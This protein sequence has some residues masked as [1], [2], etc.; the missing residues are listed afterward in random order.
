M[1]VKILRLSKAA[2]EFNVGISTIVE[3]LH[4]KG[5]DIESNPNTKIETDAYDLLLKEFQSEKTVK[6]ESQKI[7]LSYTQHE[8]ISIENKVRPAKDKEDEEQDELFIKGT[9]VPSEH[10]IPSISTEK[11]ETKTKDTPEPEEPKEPEVDEVKTKKTKKEPAKEEEVKAVE[12]PEAET[13]EETGLKVLGKIDVDSFQKKKTTKKATPAKKARAKKTEK[14][15]SEKEEPPVKP[16]E[17]QKAATKKAS[18]KKKETPAAKKEEKAKEKLPAKVEVVEKV[19]ETEAIPEAKETKPKQQEN[20]IP[21]RVEK[22]DGPKIMGK[23][24]LPAEPKK[25]EKKPV[26]SSKDD[27]IDVRKKKRRRIKKDESEKSAADKG[28]PRERQRGKSRRKDKTKPEVSEEEIQKQIKE[29]L[30]R[31]AP[32]GKSKAAFQLTSGSTQRPSHWFQ[33]SLVLKWNL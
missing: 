18:A 15:A 9:S 33:K 2:R 3:F 6:E 25:S 21:T 20:F 13:P 14:P 22:L 5:I 28:P 8:T 4:K 31:L 1:A 11:K 12:K 17:E 7:G 23:I 19:K 29:T 32:T 10:D 26:A 27:R 30:A 24:E 16:A